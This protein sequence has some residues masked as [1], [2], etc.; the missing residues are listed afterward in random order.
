MFLIDNNFDSFWE[1][2][3]QEFTSPSP[4]QLILPLNWSCFTLVRKTEQIVKVGLLM[5]IYYRY[6]DG[7]LSID[8]P[9]F[10]ELFLLIYTPE[11]QIKDTTR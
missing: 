9:M 2:Y 5:L 8:G 11:S 4:S 10:G 6:T 7:I 3:F 1:I